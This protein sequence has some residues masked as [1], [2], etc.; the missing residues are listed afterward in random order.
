MFAWKKPHWIRRSPLSKDND[1][2]ASSKGILQDDAATKYNTPSHTIFGFG[3]SS[4]WDT[5]AASSQAV[6]SSTSDWEVDNILN[7]GGSRSTSGGGLGSNARNNSRGGLFGSSESAF[8][9]TGLVGGVS[10]TSSWATTGVVSSAFEGL[11]LNH[12]V[13]GGVTGGSSSS[14]NGGD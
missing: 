3:T 2:T 9:V 12:G 5:G 14:S 11:T 6:S 8:G 10:S 7:L 1:A 4:L 13:A